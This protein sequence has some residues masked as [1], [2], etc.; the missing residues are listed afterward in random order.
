MGSRVKTVSK[1]VKANDV[2]GRRSLEWTYIGGG[3][4]LRVYVLVK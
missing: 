4:A 2:G 3:G 1:Y